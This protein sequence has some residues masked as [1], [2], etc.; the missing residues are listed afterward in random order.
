MVCPKN[1]PSVTMDLK[2]LKARTSIWPVA[3]YAP[4]G[5]RCGWNKSSKAV[6][7]LS[8]AVTVSLLVKLEVRCQLLI[9][10]KHRV[11]LAGR[12][13]LVLDLQVWIS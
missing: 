5:F 4:T 1:K 10:V 9:T 8:E 12:K 11:I 6:E 7:C 3:V 13:A 2:L